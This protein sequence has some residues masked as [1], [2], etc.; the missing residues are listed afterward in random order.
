LETDTASLG[1][2]TPAD[3][4]SQPDQPSMAREESKPKKAVQEIT[5]AVDE[6]GD[7]RVPDFSGMTMRDVT[8]ISL[9]LGLDP[10]LVGTGLAIDQ[11]P[12]AE[13]RVRHSVK[14]TVQFG[15]LSAAKGARPHKG[16]KN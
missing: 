1:D 10:V 13:A 4:F 8:E 9:R 5:V 15:T 12:R 2:L 7:I 16:S 3:F 6:G 14:I 11:E